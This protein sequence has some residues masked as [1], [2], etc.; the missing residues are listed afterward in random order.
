M[1]DLPPLNYADGSWAF[2]SIEACAVFQ[3]SESATVE[4]QFIQIMLECTDGRLLLPVMQEPMASFLGAITLTDGAGKTYSAFGIR[5]DGENYCNRTVVLFN[6]VP[7]EA[8]LTLNFLGQ[9]AVELP[10][11]AN[12]IECT[13]P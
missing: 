10:E 8:G 5:S 7:A 3:H 1:A 6:N 2:S 9:P 4:G 11:P 13:L 12:T